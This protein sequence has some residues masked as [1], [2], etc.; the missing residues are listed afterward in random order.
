MKLSRCF[1]ISWFDLWPLLHLFAICCNYSGWISIQLT[2]HLLG[3][4]IS[5][6][7]RKFNAIFDHLLFFPSGIFNQTCELSTWVFNFL[8]NTFTKDSQTVI[9]QWNSNGFPP[10]TALSISEADCRFTSC[11][12]SL[13]HWHHYFSSDCFMRPIMT[14]II[15]MVSLSFCNELLLW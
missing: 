15:Y 14:N 4:F 1:S 2:Y 12:S 9:K 7:W 10:S 6:I 3:S 13:Q 5:F 8:F 11:T